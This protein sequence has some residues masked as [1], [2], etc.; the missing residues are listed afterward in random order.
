VVHGFV[1]FPTRCAPAISLRPP[2][3][4]SIL[5][6]SFDGA[7]PPPSNPARGSPTRG[8]SSG[9]FH[10]VLE[11]SSRGF[12][13][14]RAS[15][16]GQPA[17]APSNPT[18][19]SLTLES[20]SGG[21]LPSSNRAAAASFDGAPSFDGKPRSG[22]PRIPLVRHLASRPPTY[23]G[24]GDASTGNTPRGSSH[25]TRPRR[26]RYTTRSVVAPPTSAR[27]PP[28]S[29]HARPTEK[30]SSVPGAPAPPRLSFPVLAL[31]LHDRG[32]G[33]PLLPLILRRRL[34]FRPVPQRPR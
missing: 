18:R 2:A 23:Y 12:L 1:V 26:P 11:S 24:R 14:W 29:G 8:S 5:A 22:S 13:R 7:D 20:S 10:A 6:A 31:G 17:V 32:R 16:D 3:L 9:W 30:R 25:M 21:I 27:S 15:F 28:G 34:T 19:G 33:R 4:P